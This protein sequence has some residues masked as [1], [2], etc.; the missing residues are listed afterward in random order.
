MKSPKSK[1]TSTKIKIE[2]EESA[3]LLAT[4]HHHYP[5]QFIVLFFESFITFRRKKVKIK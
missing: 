5:L 4:R 3:K 1:T 2:E